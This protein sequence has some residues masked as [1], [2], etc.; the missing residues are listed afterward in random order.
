MNSFSPANRHLEDTNLIPME[1]AMVNIVYKSNE[2][3]QLS[4]GHHTH[5]FKKL[6][7]YLY[8]RVSGVR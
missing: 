2:T 6:K 3:F 8:K 4:C 7:M 1:S 5:I